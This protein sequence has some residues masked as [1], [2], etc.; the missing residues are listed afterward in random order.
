LKHA[1]EQESSYISSSEIGRKAGVPGAQVRKDLL[2]FKAKGRP[3]V[4][5]HVLT[6]RKDL[7][8]YLGLEHSRSVALVGA[9]NLGKALAQFPGFA[10]YGMKI[11]LLLDKDPQKIG[12]VIGGLEIK[13]MDVLPLIAKEKRLKIG[14]ITTPASEAQLVAEQMVAA[15]I[16]SIWNFTPTRLS[17][18][19][20]VFI[21]YE[22]LSAGLALL[23]Q[24]AAEFERNH[25]HE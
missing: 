8:R 18:P 23:S 7:E 5:F 6:L 9:G 24:K 22:D 21:R 4:G 19:E 20:E 16:I 2:C 1:A 11:T 13:G 25:N 10:Q 15:G 3:S 14:I 12:S 17:L